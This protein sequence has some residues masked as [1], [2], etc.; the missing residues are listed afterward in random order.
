[1]NKRNT[2][3]GFTQR[4]FTKGFTL[5]ELLVVVLIIGILA[6]VAVPQYKKAVYKSRVTEGIVLLDSLVAAQEAYYWANGEHTT[7]LTKLDVEIPRELMGVLGTAK[8]EDKYSYACSQDNCSAEANNENMPYLQFNF[9]YRGDRTDNLGTRYCHVM[10]GKNDF[11]KSI[12]QSMGKLDTSRTDKWF[13]G[14]Y[15][16]LNR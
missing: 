2:R 6:A 11:A 5:I 9:Q 4:C 13:V 7:D 14:K 15:F 16:I 12:C 8:F 3:R 1:M 10:T